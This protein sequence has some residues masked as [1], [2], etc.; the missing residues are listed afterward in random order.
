VIGR[1]GARIVAVIGIFL[2]IGIVQK[3]AS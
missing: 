3:N 2:L 1:Q